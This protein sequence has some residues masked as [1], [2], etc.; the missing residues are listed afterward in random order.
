MS[1]LGDKHRICLGEV[2]CPGLKNERIYPKAQVAKRW[3]VTDSLAAAGSHEYNHL[4]SDLTVRY[5]AV[6]QKERSSF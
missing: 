6:A 1:P 3:L 4:G 2:L 5:T